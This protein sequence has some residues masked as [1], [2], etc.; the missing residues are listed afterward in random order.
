[1]QRLGLKLLK[2][3][4]EGWK[5]LVNSATA[6]PDHDHGD[7]GHS[8]DDHVDDDYD[9]DYHRGDHS[10]HGDLRWKEREHLK[11]RIEKKPVQIVDVGCQVE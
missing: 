1:M 9:Q 2:E 7:D 5:S 3:G 4:E 11:S 10:D 6:D 8:D